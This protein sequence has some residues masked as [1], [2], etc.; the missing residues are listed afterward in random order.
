MIKREQKDVD[1]SCQLEN[2]GKIKGAK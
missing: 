1:E 2:M